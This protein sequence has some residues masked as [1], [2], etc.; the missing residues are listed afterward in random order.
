[1]SQL[2]EV[3]LSWKSQKRLSRDDAIMQALFEESDRLE[4]QFEEWNREVCTL[5]DSGG[6]TSK[7]RK[8]LNRESKRFKKRFTSIQKKLGLLLI[9]NNKEIA[10]EVERN[11]ETDC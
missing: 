1:M 11:G 8:E 6:I 9:K 3:E 2:Q 10:K 7:K 5:S 4:E